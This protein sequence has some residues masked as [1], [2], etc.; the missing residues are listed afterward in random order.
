[1]HRDQAVVG[2]GVEQSA[3][4]RLRISGGEAAVRQVGDDVVI[5][6]RHG[7]LIFRLAVH[8]GHLRRGRHRRDVEGDDR[9]PREELAWVA[10]VTADGPLGRC[11]RGGG[12]FR[13]TRF[14]GFGDFRDAG[15]NSFLNFADRSLDVAQVG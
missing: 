12:E 14:D 15:Y 7:Q 11:G 2:A 4:N 5:A 1:M 3:G 10:Q 9:L 13:R 6:G 8:R